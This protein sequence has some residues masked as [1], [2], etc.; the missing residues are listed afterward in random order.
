MCVACLGGY[1]VYMEQEL[2]SMCKLRI[3]TVAILRNE[4]QIK[5]KQCE[6]YFFRRAIS[7][8]RAFD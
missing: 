2:I 6:L 4:K 5:L 8:I 3:S 1:C 7:G